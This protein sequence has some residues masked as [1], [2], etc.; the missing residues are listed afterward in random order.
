MEETTHTRWY[1]SI[2]GLS[3]L[4]LILGDVMIGITQAIGALLSIVDKF[5]PNRIQRRHSKIE[6]LE[7]K[8]KKAIANNNSALASVL[9]KQLEE[10]R[11]EVKNTLS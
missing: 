9:S 7:K 6:S 10:L 3:T 2:L 4:P 8:L 1:D 11:F 5:T